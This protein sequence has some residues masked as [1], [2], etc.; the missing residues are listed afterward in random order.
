MSQGRINYPPGNV[1]ELFAMGWFTSQ[2][3]HEGQSLEHKLVCDLCGKWS[4]TRFANEQCNAQWANLIVGHMKGEHLTE[5]T[6]YVLAETPVERN[7]I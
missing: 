5:Y 2:V 3:L 6:L 7:S 1:I 4:I